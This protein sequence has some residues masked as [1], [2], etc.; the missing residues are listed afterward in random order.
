MWTKCGLFIY[1]CR[2]ATIK[3]FLQSTS[4]P[5]GIYVRLRE[6][7]SIDAKAKTKY[8][9]NP[10]DWSA[11]KGHPINL[12]TESFKALNNNLVKF[13]TDLLNY[14][15]K[16][17]GKTTINSQ[18]LKEFIN[19][20]KKS[21]EIPNTLIGYFDFYSKHKQSSMRRSSHT[22]LHVYKHLIERFQ[23]AAKKEFLIMDV[24]ANFKLKF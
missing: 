16:C 23:K 11:T 1:L 21:D 8:A 9:I 14:Y 5:A 12:R 13:S 22:K 20:P 17:V 7:A 6:G 15:N 24:D 19:P 10:S 3:F 18:W 4:K 2:M